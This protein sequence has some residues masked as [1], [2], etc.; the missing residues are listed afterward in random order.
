[1]DV[2]GGY[3]AN[4]E[5]LCPRDRLSGDLDRAINLDDVS[6]QHDISDGHEDRAAFNDDVLG[7]DFPL[8]L[9]QSSNPILGGPLCRAHALTHQKGH[10]DR[11]DKRKAGGEQDSSPYAAL[12]HDASPNQLGPADDLSSSPRA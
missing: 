8:R 3:Q 2:A 11:R 6:T 9:P 10:A 1:M 5:G 7:C 4:T 12:K